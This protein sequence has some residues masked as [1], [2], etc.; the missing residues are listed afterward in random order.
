MDLI[1]S[2]LGLFFMNLGTN[3]VKP[4]TS[5]SY[6]SVERSGLKLLLSAAAVQPLRIHS[7]SPLPLT[8]WNQSFFIT[9][10]CTFSINP[11]LGNFVLHNT[12]ETL[13]MPCDFPLLLWLFLTF[14]HV[15]KKKTETDGL[16]IRSYECAA[17]ARHIQTGSFHLSSVLIRTRG[18]RT[19]WQRDALYECGS[20]HSLSLFHRPLQRKHDTLYVPHAERSGGGLLKDESGARSRLE[21]R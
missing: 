4:M 10:K 5:I 20:C 18:R 3:L 11:F 13:I 1:N 16:F 7:Q 2:T 9:K 17:S 12:W 8:A 19:Q 15:K 6:H 21:T 14:F